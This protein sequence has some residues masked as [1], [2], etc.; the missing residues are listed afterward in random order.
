MA[1]VNLVNINKYFGRNHVVCNLNLSVR[2]GEFL[3]LVGPSGCGKTTF[4]RM[5]A[6]LEQVS[7]GDIF[8]GELLVNDM[9][10]RERGIAMVF[11]SYAL[12]PHMTVEANIGFGLKLMKLSKSEILEKVD[13]VLNLLELDGLAGRMPREL[14]G[15]QRQRVA[16]ARALVMQPQVLLLDEP[17][18]NLDARL[19]L[20]MRTE[21]KRIHRKLQATIIYVTHD[22]TEAMTLSDRIAVMKEGRLLQ[23]GPPDEVYDHPRNMFVAGFIGSPPMNI[24]RCTLKE[25]DSTISADLKDFQVSFTGQQSITVKSEAKIPGDYLLGIRPQDLHVL[26]QGKA[27]SEKSGIYARV[28]V[29]E[30]LG[31]E[32][33][34]S[35][36]TRQQRFQ[37]VVSTGFEVKPDQGIMV[38]PDQAKCHLF[39][40]KSEQAL[41]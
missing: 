35:L 10:P 31:S 40:A 11:Q 9:P 7:K 8:I 26:H 41:F 19:R 6:G 5:I 4:I 24:L 17:L 15:G 1:G 12:F 23:V 18:S 2:D 16:L 21:L 39:D 27:V 13:N 38:F 30:S 28:E 22:Q 3:T 32:K 33:I 36:A 34:L 37:T 29:I 14:S 20:R 25:E